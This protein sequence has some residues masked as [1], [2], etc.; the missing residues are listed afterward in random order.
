MIRAL[1]LGANIRILGFAPIEDFVGYMAACDVV[2]NLRYPTVGESSGSMLRAL[3][4]G[5]AVL[6]SDVGAF[7][8]YPDEI[9]FKVP[10]GP[11]EEQYIFE[12][13]NLLVSRPEF[14]RS[15]G[16][17]ARQWVARECSWDAVAARYA[18]FLECVAQGRE[19]VEEP[20]QPEAAV[21]AELPP[22]V[23]EELAPPADAPAPDPEPAPAPEPEPAPAPVGEIEEYIIGW[24]VPGSPDRDYVDYHLT[25]LRRTLEITPPGRGED[26]VLEMGAYLQITPA[27]R[28]KLGYGDV[29]GCYYGKLGKVDRRSATSLDGEVFE[30]DVDLFDA[31]RDRFPYDDESFAT[32]LCCELIEHLESDPMHMMGEVNRILRPGGHLV[33]TTPNLAS[34]RA[35]AAILHGFHPGFF[36]AYVR[37]NQEGEVEA[38]HNREYT[39]REI[40]RLLVD[41]GFEV[42]RLETGPFREAPR[43]E[44]GWIT[45]LLDRYLLDPELR[46]D[47]IYVVGRKAGP[48]K[49]RY[50]EWLYSGGE[51]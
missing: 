43:P 2:L 50:P 18:A 19:W 12:Y 34:L 3:G 35:I 38:R 14:A 40:H 32:V 51:K 5:K 28:T 10:V 6:V 11:G 15:M 13:L 20:P 44:L 45:H 23:V 49:Q 31:E 29:R 22:P 30:C 39:P 46:G 33:L 27:L 21:T 24:T 16:A 47:G 36:P 25:R 4:L 42:V 7:H 48:L 1:D 9:C 8:E 37:P 26:C 17:R 41:A